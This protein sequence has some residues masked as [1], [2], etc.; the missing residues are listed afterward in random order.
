MPTGKGAARAWRIAISQ[1]QKMGHSS[2]KEG[3]KG[4]ACSRRIAEGVAKKRKHR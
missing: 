4:K 2:F 3:T 1:C